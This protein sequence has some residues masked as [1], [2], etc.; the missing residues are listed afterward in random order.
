MGESDRIR[1]RAG[2][3]PAS[4]HMMGDWTRGGDFF[5]A[6]LT[7]LVIGLAGDYFL[8]TEPWLVVL[9]VVAGFAV[10]FWRM[11]SHFDQAVENVTNPRLDR[12][13]KMQSAEGLASEEDEDDT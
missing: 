4:A 1:P 13:A 2:E 5:S 11:K 10:G 12:I 9:G 7:G 8:N 6:I 3:A